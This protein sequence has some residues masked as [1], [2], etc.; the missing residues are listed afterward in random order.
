VQLGFLAVIRS[1][2]AALEQ[3]YKTKFLRERRQAFKTLPALHRH[4]TGKEA[5]QD[6]KAQQALAL[7]RDSS[8]RIPCLD[9]MPDQVLQ[10]E[11]RSAPLRI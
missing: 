5:L 6:R 9:E 8:L 3:S 1:A 10:A 4:R 11:L 7:L 2:A